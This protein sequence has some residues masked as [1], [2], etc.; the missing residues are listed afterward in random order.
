MRSHSTRPPLTSRALWFSVP[1]WQS[2]LGPHGSFE[3][4]I[5]LN[6]LPLSLASISWSVIR[7][8]SQPQLLD[9]MKRALP[10][11][12][13]SLLIGAAALEGPVVVDKASLGVVTYFSKASRTG[14]QPA[15]AA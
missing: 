14:L 7:N 9:D 5:R 15:S 12:M 3:I 8:T 2:T 4:P 1:A 13:S 11:V 10:V 6:L